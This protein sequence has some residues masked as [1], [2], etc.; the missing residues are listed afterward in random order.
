[1][2]ENTTESYRFVV[3]GRVQGV[4]FRQAARMRAEQLGLRGWVRNRVDGSVE[5]VASGEVP[6][7]QRFKDWLLHG[8]PLAQVDT[9]QWTAT[10]TER[11]PG[12]V[13]LH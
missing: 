1:M 5:G 8:P 9:L 6:A 12:F 11:Q 2:S 7:L 10:T 13:V 4:G 3:A